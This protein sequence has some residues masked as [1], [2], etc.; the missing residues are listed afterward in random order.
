MADRVGQQLGNYRLTRLLGQGGFANVYLGEHV[1]LRT[2][3]AIKLLH[4][5]GVS[6][7]ELEDF[8]KE[9]Q[10]IAQL[11]HPHIVRVLEFGVDE[12]M[13]MPFLV[14]DYAPNGTLRQLYPSK[15]QQPL[16]SIISSV[17]QVSAALQY[18]HNARIIHC[19][20]KPENMLL[21]R[22]NNVLLSDFGIALLVQGSNSISTQDVTGTASYM[23]PE[24]FRGKPH[25][26]SDQYAL[27]VTVYEWLTGERPFQGSFIEL[28]T[29]HLFTPP[30]PLH[31][32]VPTISPVV[33]QVVLRALAKAP[34]DRYRSI[35]EFAKELERATVL[36]RPIPV[37]VELPLEPIPVQQKKPLHLL[38][39]TILERATMS[40]RPAPAT[41]EL[42]LEATLVQRKKTLRLP[43]HPGGRRWNMLAIFAYL[44]IL[45]VLGAETLPGITRQLQVAASTANASET[46]TAIVNAYATGTDKGVQFGFDMT[47]T[48]W[49]RYEQI[50]NATN[51]PHVTQLWSYHTTGGIGSSPTV[52]NGIVY[53]GSNDN[54][55]YAFDA[56]CRSACTPLWAYPTGG[57]GVLSSAAVA[58][59]IVYIGSGDHR[60]YAF[61]AKCRV[62]CQPLW[63]YLTGSGIGASPT[64]ANGIVYVGTN[65]HRFY[66]FD[67]KCRVACQP[68]WSYLTGDNIFSS[69][70]VANGIVYVGSVDKKFYAFD[71]KCR[72]AC[73]PLWSYLTGGDILS[74]PAV[75]N[76]IVYIGSMDKRLYAFDA[77]CRSACIPLWSYPTASYISASPAV[78][79]GVVYIGSMDH[80]LYAF[81]ARCRSACIPLWSYLTAG[82]VRSSPTVANNVVYVGSDD[83][84]IYA[85]NAACRSDC[86]PLWSYPTDGKVESGPAV[87]NGIMYVGS[88]DGSFYAFG[89]L[90]SKS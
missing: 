67:A 8:L 29:Q 27:G 75:V 48:R 53:V 26:T 54:D 63:S 81:D 83:H 30:P 80:R 32:K 56:T 57:G 21:G 6:Q 60:F 52:A 73:Q 66:A 20:V 7:E 37:I 47:H 15:T 65:D 13:Q 68:L 2:Q 35:E 12:E 39:R 50:I 34:Q 23:A 41:V 11:V 89:L 16:T 72:I 46:A 3:G 71:A 24:Q 31:E 18:A 22:D 1:Y 33:E 84:R 85:F 79:D 77:R 87:G 44:V 10:A 82:L 59:G 43:S 17:K 28:C 36:T 40:T 70:A 51:V 19:D 9:A 49:N 42:P 69:A 58:N 76:G 5:K 88:D 38:R 55:L 90:P 4:M 61:D 64:V 86:T 78:A 14:M 62:A 74:S 45:G 25:W